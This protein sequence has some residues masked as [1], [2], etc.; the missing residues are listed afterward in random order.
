[1]AVE[2]FTVHR[3]ADVDKYYKFRWWLGIT[4]G[5]MF[6][7]ASDLYPGKEALVDDNSRLT[8][9]QLRDKVDRLAIA[10][11]KLGIKSQDRVLLQ[12]P[13]WSEFVYSYFALQK[14]GA[15]PVLLVP[16][17]AQKEVG[18]LCHLTRATAW[19]LPE[20]YRNIDYMPIIED[21]L[22]ASPQLKHV[23]L[24]RGKEKERFPSLEKLIENTELSEDSLQ[25]LAARR[26]DPME[27]AHM[28]PTG[29]TTGLPKVAVRT[30][31]DL[32]CDV[33]YKDRAWELT[34]N[35]I[36]LTMAPVGHDMTFT[37][38]ICGTIFAFGKLVLLDSTLPEDFCKTVQ[39]EK[40]TCAVT[41]PALATRVANFEG[42]KDYDMSSLLKLHV[43]GAPSPPDLVRNVC[44]K[45]GCQYVIGLGSTEGLNCMTRLD[46]DLDSIC[47]TSGRPCCPYT[48]YKIIDQDER[49]LPTNT[50]G[51]LV[52][53]GPDM[54]S[55]YFN[56]PEE[57]RKSFTRD[58]FFKTGDLA[59]IDDLGRIRITGRI[60]DVILR[61][62][63]NIIPAEIERLIIT[64]PGVEDVSVIGMPDKE[65]GER[66]CA[67]IKPVSGAKPSFEEI[68]S[69]LK[70]KGASVLQ[71]PERIEFIDS[72][73]LTKVGKADK[74]ALKEDINKRLGMA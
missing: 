58:G 12:L 61:G 59:R 24:V 9:S 38:A 52:F 44:E 36:C 17:H 66:I 54:F 26:P 73:P 37:V 29:G 69:F 67:Y 23:I 3:K 65:M 63:E 40:A 25:K 7:K 70:G 55:G 30:H 68:V 62:G 39:R 45:I 60:K 53:R 43:G 2:R 64:H 34:N 15:I 22:P 35:D 71:L 56:A 46:Y 74:R 41:V 47:N 48:E 10:L 8:Y 21:V 11:I 72:I 57:N 42:L 33:E 27:L 16:K 5:D 14:V 20:K 18:H 6:D 49:G 19:I 51:E 28:G 32:I 1:M 50:D 4:L 31:N 13:N